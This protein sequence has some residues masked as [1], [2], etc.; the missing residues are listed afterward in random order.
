MNYN[1]K[2][3][4]YFNKYFYNLY[5][6]YISLSISKYQTFFLLLLSWSDYFKIISLLTKKKKKKKKKKNLDNKL[7]F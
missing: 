3:N 2:N 6:K 7:K 1:N 5:I 4:L